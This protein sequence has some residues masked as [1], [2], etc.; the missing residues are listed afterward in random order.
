MMS[1]AGIAGMTTGSGYGVAAGALGDWADPIALMAA[2]RA[3][4][5]PMEVSTMRA[6]RRD[7]LP[8]PPSVRA[9]ASGAPG[10]G[11]DHRV[12]AVGNDHDDGLLS[13][14][15]QV[16]PGMSWHARRSPARVAP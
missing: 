14:R 8:V 13:S 12:G 3:A 2:T 5:T 10:S 4:E 6:G 15:P 16:P 1:G 7:M 9:P 11:R